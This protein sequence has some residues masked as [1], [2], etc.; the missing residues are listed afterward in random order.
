MRKG[1]VDEWIVQAMYMGTVSKVELGTSTN[2][3][4]RVNVQV[5]QDSILSPLLLASITE[6]FETGCLWELPN[7][8]ICKRIKLIPGV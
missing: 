1:R 8:E 4:F 6:E 2:N 5:H 7:S 3:G